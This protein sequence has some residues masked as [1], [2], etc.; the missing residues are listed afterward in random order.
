MQKN[1]VNFNSNIG[2]NTKLFEDASKKLQKIEKDRHQAEKYFKE[3][4]IFS[5]FL[6]NLEN[7]KIEEIKINES[8]IYFCNTLLYEEQIRF[9]KIPKTIIQTHDFIN[10]NLEKTIKSI[11]NHTPEYDYVFFNED[12]R[13][14]Y[15]KN[16]FDE[17]VLKAYDKLIP[18]AF[19]ADLFRYCYIYK[20]GGWQI[21]N[22]LH[23]ISAAHMNAH[24]RVLYDG[25]NRSQNLWTRPQ[26][27]QPEQKALL[28]LCELPVG[29]DDN[30]RV[31]VFHGSPV[32][33]RQTHSLLN[34]RHVSIELHPV[35]KGVIKKLVKA[36]STGWL[37]GPD[38]SERPAQ[39]L[40]HTEARCH[41]PQ[42]IPQTR[43]YF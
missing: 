31:H 24:R 36:G 35:W 10:D 17:I 25:L 20:E 22:T 7:Y 40:G 38:D 34:H 13:Q 39:L 14:E 33:R 5:L 8:G 2:S 15:I 19:K 23:V 1:I 11:K 18:K 27:P 12:D 16:N 30:G 42:A 41:C 26:L 6:Y 37:P 32:R 43:A 4:E 29:F 21:R 3:R 28:V 9:T